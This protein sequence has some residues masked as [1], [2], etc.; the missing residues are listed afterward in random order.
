[1]SRLCIFLII[2]CLWSITPGGA[3]TGE[4]SIGTGSVSRE[5]PKDQ[6]L[7]LKR[8]IELT[9]FYTDDSIL[10]F[11]SRSTPLSDKNYQPSDLVTL[12]GSGIDEAG[13]RGYLRKEARD[14]LVRMA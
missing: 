2:L 10:R 4:T 12:A 6:Y 1:M 13:R 9:A 11:V 8:K 14:A 7:I 5:K 3:Q